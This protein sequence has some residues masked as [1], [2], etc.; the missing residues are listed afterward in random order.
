MRYASKWIH[1]SLTTNHCVALN[2]VQSTKLQYINKIISRIKY[3]GVDSAVH[4][5]DFQPDLKS[6]DVNITTN[7]LIDYL[8]QQSKKTH[9]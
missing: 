1:P 9:K 4:S 2:L 8:L 6:K 3:D 7:L 5:M